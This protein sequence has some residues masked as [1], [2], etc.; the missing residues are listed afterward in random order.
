[1]DDLTDA[2]KVA[3]D[4]PGSPDVSGL[5]VPNGAAHSITVYAPDAGCAPTPPAVAARRV[6][7]QSPV[8][9]IALHEAVT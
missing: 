4:D 6:P 2:G 9:L 8:N 7:Y 3:F 1:M 5:Y